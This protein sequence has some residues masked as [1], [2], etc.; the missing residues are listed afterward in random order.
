MR[1]KK[2][3]KKRKRKRRKMECEWCQSDEQK[4]KE[5]VC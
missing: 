5:R 3:R 2:K 4:R 1:R